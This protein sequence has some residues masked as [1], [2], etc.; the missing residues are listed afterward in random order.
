M[1]LGML[2][3]ELNTL[4]TM[5]PFIS[6]TR[7]KDERVQKAIRDENTVFALVIRQ[8]VWEPSK[9]TVTGKIKD[10]FTVSFT[11]FCIFAETS[12]LAE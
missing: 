11:S 1:I 8:K 2:G 6:T 9:T 7:V 10:I 3:N 4:S 5:G 12:K